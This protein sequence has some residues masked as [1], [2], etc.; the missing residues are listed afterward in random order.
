MANDTVMMVTPNGKKYNVPREQV[1]AMTSKYGAKPYMQTGS[2]QTKPG[3]PIS[4]APTQSQQPTSGGPDMLSLPRGILDILKSLP[5]FGEAHNPDSVLGSFPEKQIAESSDYRSRAQQAMKQGD[6]IS[7]LGHSI[8]SVL[9]PTMLP[10]TVEGV[11]NTAQTDPARAGGQILGMG[12]MEKLP[13]AGEIASNSTD[14]ARGPVR[15]VLGVGKDFEKRI[16]NEHQTALTDYNAKLSQIMQENRRAVDEARQTHAQA[17]ENV[18]KQNAEARNA[19]QEK[20]NA[21]RQKYSQQVAAKEGGARNA[22]ASQSAAETKRSAL[23]DSPRSGPVFQRLQSMTNQVYGMIDNLQ[24]RIRSYNQTRWRAFDTAVDEAMKKKGQDGAQVDWTPVQQA[25]KDAED[26]ILKGSPESISIFRNIMKES[27][28]LDQASVFKT[29][30][31]LEAAGNLKEILR[32]ANP[33]MK[34]QILANLHAQGLTEEDVLGSTPAGT[35]TSG[36]PGKNVQI[37]FADARG[38][39]TELGSKL[40]GAQLPGD[41][42]RAID[43]VRNIADQQIEKVTKDAGQDSVYRNLKDEYKTYKQNFD[44]PQSAIYQFDKLDTPEKR[45]DFLSSGKGQNLIDSL[46]KYKGFGSDPNLPGRVR[47]LVRQLRDL[48]TEKAAPSTPERPSF[49]KPPELKENPVGPDFSGMKEPPDV[50]EP[51]DITR[52]RVEQLENMAK[53]WSQFSPNQARWIGSGIRQRIVG[54]LLSSPSVRAWVAGGG[55]GK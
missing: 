30:Q 52:K 27:P 40:Y 20:I 25:V 22:S 11:Y 32:D 29:G 18:Q 38:Y 15:S 2:Y 50:V 28:Q 4:V 41:V 12:L 24:D 5:Q 14:L 10:E 16:A 48:P 23:G 44:D 6:P 9:T 39:F 1:S 37:P 34:R 54:K 21:I 19:Y 53:T 36:L 47:S 51:L 7:F 55:P 49:P 45:V 35:P 8:N 26:K 31:T 43:H 17:V 13:E 42:Y 33:N 46:S 3:G